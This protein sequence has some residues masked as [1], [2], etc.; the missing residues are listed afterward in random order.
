MFLPPLGDGMASFSVDFFLPP[1]D[2]E[3]NE[4]G[5][6]DR[7]AGVDDAATGCDCNTTGVG[8]TGDDTIWLYNCGSWNDSLHLFCDLLMDLIAYGF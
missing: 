8:F 5:K 3:D 1:N 2:S 7:N 4:R 6:R